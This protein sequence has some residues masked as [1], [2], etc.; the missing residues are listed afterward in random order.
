M[1]QWAIGIIGLGAAARNIHLP[2]IRKLGRFKLVGGVDP[3]LQNHT[4]SFPIFKSLQE[5]M[6]AVQPEI[7]AIV[8]PPDSHFKLICEGLNAGAHIFCEKPFVL[9]LEEGRRVIELS[10]T[11]ERMIVVNNEFR[12]MNIHETA[13]NEISSSRFGDLHF[14][15]MHQTFFVTK[16][17]EA[18]W[19]GESKQRTCF[20]FGTHTLD[21]CRYFFGEEPLS[22][23]ARMPKPDD[24]NGPDYLNLIQLEFSG[25]RFAHITLDRLSRGPHR[26]LDIRLD[27]SKGCIESKLGGLAEFA[28]GIKGGTRKPFAR[29]EITPGGSARIFD[30]DKENLLATD[31][32]D[33]FPNATSKLLGKML[34]ALEA[35]ATPPCSAEDNLNTLALM[36]AAYDSSAQSGQPIVLNEYLTKA[37]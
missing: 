20:E 24:K 4:F 14:I 34:D 25:D 13:N 12:F 35:G 15:S 2:A 7:L 29:F 3:F 26:Y 6:T 32:I 18:G 22:I 8:T 21:L 27:G 31:P 37:G 36:L 5:M 10:K 11:T 17:T 33:L 9:S 28:F 16:E 30:N 23:S 1:R 19:R